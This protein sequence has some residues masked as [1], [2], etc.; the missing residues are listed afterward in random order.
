MLFGYFAY[1]QY[2]KNRLDI[3]KIESLAQGAL[4]FMDD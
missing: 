3:I 2:G 4:S 1:I